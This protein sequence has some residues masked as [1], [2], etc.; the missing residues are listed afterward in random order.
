M[1]RTPRS[2]GEL[3]NQDLPKPTLRVSV[4]AAMRPRCS[5]G[6]AWPCA[7]PAHP[8]ATLC[9]TPSFLMR[10]WGVDR[11]IPRRVA[12]PRGPDRTP[13]GVLEDGQDMRTLSFSEALMHATILVA[14]HTR[15]KRA[16]LDTPNARLI[17]H[18]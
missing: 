1:S 3:P 9:A 13:L 6:S 12:A 5:D 15:R 11:F 16:T 17:G 14:L 4:G 2:R 8:A 7:R 18:W 10:N